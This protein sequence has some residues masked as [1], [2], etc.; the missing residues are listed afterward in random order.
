MPAPGPGPAPP[1]PQAQMPFPFPGAVPAQHMAALQQHNQQLAQWLSNVHRDATTRV[2]VNQNQRGRAHAGMRGIGD[3]TRNNGQPATTA[4]GRNSPAPG[5]AAQGFPAHLQI[6]DVQ[7]ALQAADRNEVTQ[8]MT[9]LMQRS[10]SS[11]SLPSLQNRGL[12]QP[13]VTTPIFPGGAGSR[14]GSR[15]RRATPEPGH[16]GIPG[17]AQAPTSASSQGQTGYEVYVLSSPEGPR[18]LLLNHGTSE[19]YYTP[20]LRSQA[21]LPQMRGFSPMSMLYGTQ[22]NAQ[23]QAQAGPQHHLQATQ[24]A[25]QTPQPQEQGQHGVVAQ[26]PQPPQPPQPQQPQQPQ[27]QQQQQQGGGLAHPNNPLPPLLI[28]VWP[29][30][31][32]FVK[33]SFFVLIINSPDT[34]WSR[35]FLVVGVAL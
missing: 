2:L 29:H 5:Q 27:Q 32:L 24:W 15:S 20:R 34:P 1:Q 30:I 31:W 16:A 9:D 4:S 14:A 26:P 35:W 3:P 7:N 25:P 13:G 28:Q 17:T 23:Y 18:A 21:S 10:A 8:A 12:H 22:P 33:L 19:T 11:A 6:R